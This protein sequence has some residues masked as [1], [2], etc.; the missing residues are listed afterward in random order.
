MFFLVSFD[1]SEIARDV[2]CVISILAVR[3]AMEKEDFFCSVVIADVIGASLSHKKLHIHAWRNTFIQNELKIG[4]NI[5]DLVADVIS[6]IWTSFCV[7]SSF[8]TKIAGLSHF[9]IG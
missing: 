5:F 9:I 6:G 4:T 3:I 1:E 8:F 2:R 7:D